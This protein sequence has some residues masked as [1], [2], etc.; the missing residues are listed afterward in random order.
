MTKPVDV[1]AIIARVKA[2]HAAEN[3]AAHK[4]TN[5][6]VDR[7]ADIDLVLAEMNAKY[8]VVQIG[9]KTRVM[10]FEDDPTYHGCK[11]PVFQTIADFKAFHDKHKIK[12]G[13]K[14]L[15]GR[16]NW[17]IA[18]SERRQYEAVVYAPRLDTSDN[19]YNLWQ[20]FT[21]EPK[22][23]NCQLYLD[24]LYKNICRDNKEHYT[25]LLH[26]LAYGVQHP[27]KQGE[28]AVVLRG[29]EGTGK[30]KLV[31]TYGSLFGSHFKHIS[32]PRHLVGNFNSLQH[33][34]SVLFGDEVFFAGD[35]T[36]EGILKAIIT[37]PTLQIER[38]GVD[39]FTAPNRMHIFLSSNNDWVV[40]AG[41]DARRFF[42]LDVGDDHKQDHKYFAAIDKQMANGGREALLHLLL[43]LDL[44]GF[45][46]RNV[47]Q[48]A[49]LADQKQRTRRGIDA[50][51]EHLAGEGEL[52]EVRPGYPSMC[53]TSER[54]G[55][56]SFY[57]QAQ[58]MAPDL[59]HS[60]WTVVQKALKEEWGCEHWRANGLNGLKFLPLHALRAR[61]DHKYGSQQW[62]RPK[63]DWGS[64]GAHVGA[65][66]DSRD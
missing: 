27:D 12:T 51:I 56:K 44:T 30:G 4:A 62:E 32:N 3:E 29:K 13:K 24:H 57:R 17:W 42:V 43:D 65:N 21:C 36:H 52:W 40:P 48:T 18:H 41:S 64:Q 14:K 38:K 19:V 55:H 39:T 63:D 20:G 47:P 46:V 60:T 49:A 26:K 1:A 6:G 2:Q 5:G 54:D 61:F 25:Y 8:A 9:G 50:V 10:G 45:E 15:V 37:E 58:S 11:V 28:V 59:R 31:L 35:R 33:D 34:C 53:I 23:G 22:A 66:H 16:G 7:Q